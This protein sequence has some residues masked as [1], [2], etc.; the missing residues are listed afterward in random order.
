MH[1]M[2][3]LLCLPLGG[4][5]I[6]FQILFHQFV[7]AFCLHKCIDKKYVEGQETVLNQNY[8]KLRDAALLPM[9]QNRV[10]AQK[11]AGQEQKLSH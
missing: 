9:Q 11:L 1:H 4:I 3:L 7:K 10:I 2:L 8:S 5:I 6:F